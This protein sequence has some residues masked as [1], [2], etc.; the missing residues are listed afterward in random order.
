MSYAN[1]SLYPPGDTTWSWVEFYSRADWK[2]KR[3]LAIALKS[4]KVLGARKGVSWECEDRC[5]DTGGITHRVLIDLWKIKLWLLAKYVESMEMVHLQIKQNKLADYQVTN[6]AP[7]T[8]RKVEAKL[9]IL[10][11]YSDVYFCAS[12]IF[13]DAE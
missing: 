4:I 3:K 5:R 12:L 7:N 2:T 6:A 11:V 8:F 9:C 13:P 10:L 1:P